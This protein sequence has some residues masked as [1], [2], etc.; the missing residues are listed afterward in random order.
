MASN[1]LANQ[2]ILHQIQSSLRFNM[3]I[4]NCNLRNTFKS[5]NHKE[6]ISNV[7]AGTQKLRCGNREIEKCQS[8]PLLH[9]YENSHNFASSV[10]QVIVSILYTARLVLVNLPLAILTEIGSIPS[11]LIKRFLHFCIVTFLL[12]PRLRFPWYWRKSWK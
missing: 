4:T 11:H 10:Y 6:V 12:L 3:I 1:L 5:D 9:Q 7:C 2:R 8:Q